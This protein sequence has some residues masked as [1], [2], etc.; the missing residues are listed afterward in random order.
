VRK[1]NKQFQNIRIIKALS[2]Q[3]LIIL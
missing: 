3:D 2:N 1:S